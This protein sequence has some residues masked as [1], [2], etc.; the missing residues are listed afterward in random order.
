METH[1]GTPVENPHELRTRAQARLGKAD[2]KRS[3]E[4]AGRARLDGSRRRWIAGVTGR[5][6]R[7]AVDSGAV[8]GTGEVIEAMRENDHGVEAS[9]VQKFEG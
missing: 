5:R 7:T 9:V 8:G 3:R 6:W 4:G 1:G 2:G